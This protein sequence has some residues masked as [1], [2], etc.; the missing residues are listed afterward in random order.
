MLLFSYQ[1]DYRFCI[2]LT[3]PLA[4]NVSSGIAEFEGVETAAL[5]K[6]NSFHLSGFVPGNSILHDYSQVNQE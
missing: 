1:G 2:V 6:S 3:E 5:L 4:D